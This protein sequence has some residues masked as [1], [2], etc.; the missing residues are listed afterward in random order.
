M[1]FDELE[2]RISLVNADAVRQAVQEHLYD[3][4]IALAGVGKA[5]LRLLILNSKEKS[6]FYIVFHLF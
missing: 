1:P 6:I 3:R 2:R 5:F 4:D